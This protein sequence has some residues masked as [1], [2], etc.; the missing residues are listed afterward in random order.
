MIVIKAIYKNKLTIEMN[1]DTL[2]LNL[3]YEK[4][5][6]LY[7]LYYGSQYETDNYKTNDK[8]F[9]VDITTDKL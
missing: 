9:V 1:Y 8:Y 5:K 7:I 3:R 6:S 4:C 2:E